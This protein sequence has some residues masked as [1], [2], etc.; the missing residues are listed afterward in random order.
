MSRV[1]ILFGSLLSLVIMLN[2][3]IF[4]MPLLWVRWIFAAWTISCILFVFVDHMPKFNGRLVALIIWAVLLGSV[5]AIASATPALLMRRLFEHYSIGQT[6]AMF[7]VLAVKLGAIAGSLF[8]GKI[9]YERFGVMVAIGGAAALFACF[10]ILSVGALDALACYI[11]GM[12]YFS[13][14]CS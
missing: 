14:R 10:V 2:L 13:D 12:T 7:I 9:L 8:A 3:A 6:G 4:A 5:L 1:S 11:E